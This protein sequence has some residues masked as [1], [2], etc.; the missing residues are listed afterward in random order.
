ML[1]AFVALCLSAFSFHHA[2]R[3]PLAPVPVAHPVGHSHVLAQ[4][5]SNGLPE[6]GFPYPASPHFYVSTG[7]NDFAAG[8]SL[9]PLLTIQEA[10]NRLGQSGWT[11][12]PIVTMINKA[13]LGANPVINVPSPP[14]GA[15]EIVIQG[16]YIDSGLGQ[17]TPTGGTIGTLTSPPALATVVCAASTFTNHANAG[18]VLSFD[19]A[20]TGS[21]AG[22]RAMITDNST[23]TVTVTGVRAAAPS[24]SDVFHIQDLAG[25][26]SFTGV[27]VLNAPGGVYLDGLEITGDVAFLVDG[28]AEWTA[29]RF[30][31]NT[32]AGKTFIVGPV[33]DGAI[34]DN[35]TARGFAPPLAQPVGVTACGSRYSGA[36]GGLTFGGS[37]FYPAAGN[38]YTEAH[39]LVSGANL[40]SNASTDRIFLYSND[41]SSIDAGG[42][43]WG[44]G[45]LNLFR[46]VMTNIAKPSGAGAYIDVSSTQFSGMNLVLTGGASSNDLIHMDHVHGTLTGITGTNASAGVAFTLK[47]SSETVTDASTGTTLSGASASVDV[48]V[49]TNAATLLGAGGIKDTA[50]ARVDANTATYFGP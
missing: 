9:Q 31:A 46:E 33:N 5:S 23:T 11:G 24:A 37:V 18:M 3:P 45:A 8:T 49:G 4:P 7:G 2:V 42:V 26:W 10:L 6:S 1:T 14:A 30:I 28:L 15:Q 21:N 12:Q 47:H 27:M 29:M 48:L 17:L 43:L 20:G 38:I 44:G 36:T 22:A 16:M 13:A 25:G 19:S 34:Y 35:E 32:S 50:A 41:I 40:G 39:S